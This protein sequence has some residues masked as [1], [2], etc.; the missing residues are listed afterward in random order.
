MTDC[1]FCKMVQKEIKAKIAYEDDQVLA[2]HDINPQAPVHLLI[3]PKQHLDRVATMKDADAV[4]VGQLIY[5]AK[6]IA[7]QNGWKYYRLVLNDGEESGQSIFH[8]HLHLL[9]GRRMK[10]PPG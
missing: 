7:D 9:T 4:M 8:I 1:L 6:Q 2:I 3:F 10:W 5:R